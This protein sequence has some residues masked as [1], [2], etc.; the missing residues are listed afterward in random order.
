M[1]ECWRKGTEKKVTF[2]LLFLIFK[3][4][5][6]D[7]CIMCQVKVNILFLQLLGEVSDIFKFS[8]CQVILGEISRGVSDIIPVK[9]C[10]QFD[11][12]C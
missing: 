12:H 10:Y 8:K 5:L 7:G 2:V 3:L 9:N 4:H 6:F 11:F 1:K